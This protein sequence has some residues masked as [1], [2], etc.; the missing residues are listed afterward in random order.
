MYQNTAQEIAMKKIPDPIETIEP[1]QVDE[2]RRRFTKAGFAGSGII[3]TVASQPVWGN[4]C[5]VSGMMSG[6]TSVPHQVPCGG[7]T[8]GYW[9]ANAIKRGAASWVGYQP[10]DSFNAVFGVGDYIRVCDNHPFTLLE[11]MQM[12]GNDDP[13]CPRVGGHAVAALLN[14]AS[15]PEAYGY[16]AS[17]IIQMF[18]NYSD[19]GAFKDML[20]MLNNRG[21]PLNN[22][23]DNN[24]STVDTTCYSK[25]GK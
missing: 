15:F 12:Q 5:S 19:C 1:T 6:N 16:T 9:K 20:D 2:S 23:N 24:N 14:A 25:P 13:R 8:P 22:A 11:V 21:C 17:N 7:C 10:G 3:L 18:S 4:H